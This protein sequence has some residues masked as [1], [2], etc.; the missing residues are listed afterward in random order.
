L[1]FFYPLGKHPAIKA[2]SRITSMQLLGFSGR[3]I[4]VATG[5]VEITAMVDAASRKLTVLE[6]CAGA[7]GQAIGLERS[8]F[9][10]VASIELNPD[11]CTTLR[12]NRP[13]W[14]VIEANVF[15]VDG[16]EFAGV[17]LLAGG[18]PCPP[19]ST[20]GKQLGSDDERDLFPQALRLARESRPAAVLLE[21]VRGFASSKFE[22]YR[23]NLASDLTELGYE[24]GWRI[25]RASAF[26]VPQLRPRFVLVALLPTIAQRFA[27]PAIER[28]PPTVGQALKP[29]MSARGWSGAAAWAEKAN[30]IAPTIVGGSHKHGGADLGPTRAKR[31]WETLGVDAKGIVDF[32]PGIHDSNDHIPRLTINMVARLQGFPDEW[33][34]TG[35]K[36]SAYRQ[37]GNAFPPPVAE[38]VGIAIYRAL[39]GSTAL[40]SSQLRL[41]A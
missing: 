39:V 21:N 20:A 22:G 40:P 13:L 4:D 32:A 7:G 5:G 30:R 9:T 15:D 37:V 11:A 12:T 14:N 34:I 33:T 29:L 31:E 8:G 26:G 25:L 19:F 24:V 1:L 2:K 23:R 27:W 35:A 16:K 6:I 10:H 41:P 38:Q 17:E 18:V 36:T 28:T 3:L